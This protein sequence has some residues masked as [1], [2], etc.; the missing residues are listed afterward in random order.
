MSATTSFA[1]VQAAMSVLN[2]VY[3]NPIIAALVRHEVADHLEPDPLSAADLARRSGLNT[4]ALTRVLRAL[5]AFG[6]FK[7]IAPGVFANNSVSKLFRHQPGGFA[8]LRSTTPLSTTSGR[9]Q[10]WRIAS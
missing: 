9:P 3:F 4:L 6:A 2:H 7:E 10:P 5:A 1:D 8:T